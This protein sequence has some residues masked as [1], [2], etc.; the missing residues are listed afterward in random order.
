MSLLRRSSPRPRVEQPPVRADVRQAYVAWVRASLPLVAVT[1]V[2][3]ALQQALI[4][5]DPG[6]PPDAPPPLRGMLIA[7]AAG[8]VLSGRA[9]RGR[10][11]QLAG[12]LT[13]EKAIRQARSASY[14]LLG[15]ALAPVV[16]GV[17]VVLISRS[18]VDLY[19]MLGITL[20]GFVLLFPRVEQW[21]AWIRHLTGEHM[22]RVD[23]EP[24]DSAL[25]P[26]ETGEADR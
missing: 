19:L 11:L 26:D 2:A 23:D 24:V 12:G 25:D 20:L 13:F 18:L 9:F 1:L 21:D 22:R 7:V 10:P 3:I 4:A 16:M 6:A 15:L 8:A 5:A 14:T 17:L